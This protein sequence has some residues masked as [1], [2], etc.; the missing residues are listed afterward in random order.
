ML[1][2]D[3]G[4][5]NRGFGQCFWDDYGW[6]ILSWLSMAV[7]MLSFPHPLEDSMLCITTY[8][9]L[10]FSFSAET[11]ISLLTK[12]MNVFQTERFCQVIS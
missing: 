1:K 11:I 6:R 8:T 2:D 5:L 12:P 3:E 7:K 10:V 9:C 4:P